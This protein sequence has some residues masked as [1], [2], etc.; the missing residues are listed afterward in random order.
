[1][2]LPTTSSKLTVRWQGPYEILRSI[3][4][5][6]YLVNLHDRHKSKRVFHVN[7]LRE[8]HAPTSTNYFIEEATD[9]TD[10]EDVMPSWRDKEGGQ[11]KFGEE[12]SSEQKEKLKE[13]LDTY[14]DVLT[15][16]PGCTNL[17]SHTI[18]TGDARPYDY[19]PIDYRRLIE[20]P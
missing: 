14:T 6:N 16:T 8:W 17:A 1:M 5:V 4:K 9:D 3:G 10:L 20:Q 13:V 15:A 7:M 18:T 12:L 11:I 19:H 2:L